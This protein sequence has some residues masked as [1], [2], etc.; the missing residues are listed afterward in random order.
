MLYKLEGGE[1][2]GRA[3][4]HT[5]FSAVRE[6]TVLSG[7][8]ACLSAPAPSPASFAV[9]ISACYLLVPFV[10]L[11]FPAGW[12][13]ASRVLPPTP[14]PGAPAAPGSPGGTSYMKRYRNSQHAAQITHCSFFR[15]M[16]DLDRFGRQRSS[17]EPSPFP[18]TAP[19]N[20]FPK[21]PHGSRKSSR[22]PN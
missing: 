10:G 7:V 14:S 8:S 6:R 13:Q 3:R 16:G 22:N 4:F 12:E 20:D 9:V 17:C 18:K 2:Q 19:L 15:C 11:G 21:Y 1:L 5:D